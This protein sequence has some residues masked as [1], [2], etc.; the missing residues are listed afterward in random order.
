MS[1]FFFRKRLTNRLQ[2][3][4][5]FQNLRSLFF[6][7]LALHHSFGQ[8][9]SSYGQQPP[10]KVQL[11]D[12]EQDNL[13]NAQPPSSSQ[14]SPVPQYSQYPTQNQQQLLYS[15]PPQQGVPAT[16]QQ[17]AGGIPVFTAPQQGAAYQAG[18]PQQ[19]IYYTQAPQQLSPYE[20]PFFSGNYPY[21]PQ[22]SQ[23]AVPA[24][25]TNLNDYYKSLQATAG[26]PGQLAPAS[27]KAVP[28]VPQVPAYFL[29]A[30]ALQQ[31]YYQPVSLASGSPYLAYNAFY[32]LQAAQKS[33]YSAGVKSTTPAVPTKSD[34]KFVPIGSQNYRFE[35]TS[36]DFSKPDFAKLRG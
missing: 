8:Q 34:D 25:S 28:Q 14:G 32:P 24:A 22:A 15:L 6:F 30:A 21:V 26:K 18:P 7:F 29:P 12:I 23:P 16:S 11:E 3:I 27:L 5:L 2:Y 10:S 36:P 33:V 35:Y 17:Q 13:K 20:L 9:G 4:C 1:Y 19:F 31:P